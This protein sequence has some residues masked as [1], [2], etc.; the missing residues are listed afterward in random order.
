MLTKNEFLALYEKYM[1]GQCTD[2]EKRLLDTYRDE[3][4]VKAK[5]VDTKLYEAMTRINFTQC[6]V[7]LRRM[8]K[9]LESFPWLNSPEDTQ[10]LNDAKYYL[11]NQF[12]LR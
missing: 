9:A 11:R 6:A 8:V 5:K 2:A 10:R 12:K 1:S 4:L 7:D 3:M